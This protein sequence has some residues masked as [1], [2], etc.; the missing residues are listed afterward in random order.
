MVVVSGTNCGLSAR[1]DNITI[2]TLHSR[3]RVLYTR[4]K[5]NDRLLEKF[6][7][8][9]NVYHTNIAGIFLYILLFLGLECDSKKDQKIKGCSQKYTLVNIRNFK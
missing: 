8:S 5:L 1:V 7:F 6:V 2:W 3:W 9:H 4:D